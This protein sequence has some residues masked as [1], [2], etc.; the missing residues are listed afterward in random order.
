MLPMKFY[1]YLRDRREIKEDVKYAETFNL[2]KVWDNSDQLNG[3]NCSLL[4]L[5]RP[6]I[7]MISGDF[8]TQWN[9]ITVRKK[10][11]GSEGKKRHF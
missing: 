11:R 2:P 7:P 1:S 3:N 10:E 8:L 6:T 9:A 4:I 5:I